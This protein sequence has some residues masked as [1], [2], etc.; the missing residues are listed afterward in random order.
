MSP[1]D[2]LQGLRTH[3]IIRLPV[4]S[5]QIRVV[6]ER[7][8][9][10]GDILAAKARATLFKYLSE[11]EDEQGRSYVLTSDSNIPGGDSV[12]I[13][14][15]VPLERADTIVSNWIMCMTTPHLIVN[16][17]GKNLVIASPLRS[18]IRE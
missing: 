4:Q 5:D 9:I 7:Q 10:I 13:C 2:Y 12:Y 15:R 1:W 3:N 8:M 14:G 17:C 18:F 16:T 11:T 6:L